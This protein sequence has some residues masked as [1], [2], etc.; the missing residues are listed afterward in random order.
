MYQD[1]LKEAPQYQYRSTYVNSVKYLSFII[2]EFFHLAW[3]IYG[4]KL[5]YSTLNQCGE[6]SSLLSFMMLAV[7]IFGYFRFLFYITIVV[8]IGV[9]VYM[10]FRRRG[11]KKRNSKQVLKNLKKVKY[12]TI[13]KQAKE[14]G[15]DIS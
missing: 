14:S 11:E 5:Y 12:S 15:Q 4:N 7:L 9:I 13:E 2:L 3:L 10:R 1:Y 8:V 6:Q